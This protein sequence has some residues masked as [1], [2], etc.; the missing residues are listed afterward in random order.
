MMPKGYIARLVYDRTHL[1]LAIVRTPLEVIGGITYRPFKERR[2]AEI[3]FC[4]VSSDQ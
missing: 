1:S 2:F 4:A 3:V